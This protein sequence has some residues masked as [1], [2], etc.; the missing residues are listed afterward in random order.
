LRSCVRRYTYHLVT[1]NYK[2]NDMESTNIK[3]VYM[4]LLGKVH[5]V[6]Y[7][8]CRKHNVMLYFSF[9]IAT[10]PSIL[11]LLLKFFG[12]GLEVLRAVRIHTVVCI[13]TL[14][15]LVHGYE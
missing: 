2:H 7:H 12:T 10:F 8:V 14:Y 13:R 6:K 1:Q 3:T 11:Q 15:G 5:N 9:S 4:Q